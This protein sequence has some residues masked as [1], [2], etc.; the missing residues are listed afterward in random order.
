[1]EITIDKQ[2]TNLVMNGL[3]VSFAVGTDQKV[4]SPRYKNQKARC[5]TAFGTNWRP[6][7]VSY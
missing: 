1:M 7:L 4:G 3:T 2:A 6:R 5:A